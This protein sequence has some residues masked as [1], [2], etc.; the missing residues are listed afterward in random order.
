MGQVSSNR[1]TQDD[2]FIIYVSHKDEPDYL[3]NPVS[4][5]SIDEA[6]SII[7]Y[8]FKVNNNH[9]D[10]FIFKVRDTNTNTMYTYNKNTC[11]LDVA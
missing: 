7:E 1:V 3:Q 4:C 11:N 8:E 10:E 2:M 6:K 9:L 5:P